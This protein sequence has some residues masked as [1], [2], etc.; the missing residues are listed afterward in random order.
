MPKTVIITATKKRKPEYYDTYANALRE[1]GL[2]SKV[3]YIEELDAVKSNWRYDGVL[4]P[5]G[6]DVD[7][8]LYNQPPSE[9]LGSVDTELDTLELEIINVARTKGVPIFGICRGHQMINVALGGS[10]IQHVPEHD[11]HHKP[12]NFLA[13]PIFIRDLDSL[14]Y[15][16]A[17]RQEV[18]VNS[19]HHQVVDKVGGGMKIVALG[20]DGSPEATEHES[21]PIFSVQFHPEELVGTRA[22][23][24]RLFKLFADRVK[25][26]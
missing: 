9:H 5:G 3:V 25:T 10:L 17:K 19:L 18:L 1:A 8:K 4:L 22:W 14:L 12:R 15:E 13:H 2:E 20:A 6:P 16:A 26:S 24:R 21:E 7:P 11:F 23:I